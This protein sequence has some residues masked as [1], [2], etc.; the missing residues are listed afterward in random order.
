MLVKDLRNSPH[1]CIRSHLQF[2]QRNHIPSAII[3]GVI[4]TLDAIFVGVLIEINGLSRLE[5]RENKCWDGATS[6][7]K[8][9]ENLLA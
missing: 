5:R 8:N 1:K 2:L 7:F 9:E 4:H 3:D 6:V